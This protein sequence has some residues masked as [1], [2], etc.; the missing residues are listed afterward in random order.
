MSE[1]GICIGEANNPRMT[2]INAKIIEIVFDN[3]S[4]VRCTPNHLFMTNSGD[5]IRAKDLEPGI[6][7]MPLYRSISLKGGWANYERV[8]CPIKKQRIL[9][10]KLVADQYHSQESL[11]HK[12]VHHRDGN[13]RNNNPHNLEFLT[14]GGHSSH[15]I[16][17]RCEKNGNFIKRL[18]EGHKKYRESGGNEKSRETIL[19]LFEEGK[20]FKRQKVCSVKGCS[21]KHYGLGLCEMHY[22][23]LKRAEIRKERIKKYY[24][25]KT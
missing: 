11:F 6:S 10:H 16:K 4:V 24:G 3:Y 1:D 2:K 7:I 13:K 23:R 5:Y 20:L 12:I 25:R 22:K 15:H 21:K 14:Q 8:Y 19:R 17:L 18:R 9:T